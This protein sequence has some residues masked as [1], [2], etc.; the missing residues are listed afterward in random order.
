MYIEILAGEFTGMDPIVAWD[1]YNLGQKYRTMEGTADVKI[2]RLTDTVRVAWRFPAINT[3]PDNLEYQMRVTNTVTAFDR[4][5]EKIVLPRVYDAVDVKEDF[6]ALKSA[7]IEA[8][9]LDNDMNRKDPRHAVSS[10]VYHTELNKLRTKAIFTALLTNLGVKYGH[11]GS[12]SVARD[13]DVE[14]FFNRD[15]VKRHNVP[16]MY[17][18][19]TKPTVLYEQNN[20]LF[21]GVSH[22]SFQFRKPLP[23]QNVSMLLLRP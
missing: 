21:Q 6:L 19:K 5:A 11:I 22:V 2:A 13:V 15:G 3:Q 20:A 23:L 14:A 1:W 8:I 18:S 9:E 10:T 16:P 4:K 12:C 7:V 17:R